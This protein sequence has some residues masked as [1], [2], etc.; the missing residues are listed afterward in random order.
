MVAMAAPVLLALSAPVTLTLRVLP[1]RPRRRLVR[2]LHSRAVAALTA[3]V[4]A[5]ILN[6]GGLCLLY[7]TPLYAASERDDLVHAA[8]HL[9]MFVSGCLLSWVVVG[10]DPL[11][12]TF[13]LRVRLLVLVAAAAGHDAVS[14]LMYARDLP[15]GAGALPGR[16]VGAE[17]MYYGATL[18]DLL[19]AAVVMAQWWHVTGRE[20]ARARRRAERA[21]GPEGRPLPVRS[22]EEPGGSV[23]VA[24]SG[25]ADRAKPETPASG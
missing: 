23:S 3:G 6:V 13:R 24:A 20:L 17:L 9:H 18:V 16:H 1:A 14:K 5:V 22:P 15:A 25:L 2:L 19:V 12:S 10:P 7:L 4:T 11:R 21:P 8:V